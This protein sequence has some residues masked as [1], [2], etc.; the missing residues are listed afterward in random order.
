MTSSNASGFIQLD[1]RKRAQL[2]RFLPETA[3]TDYRIDVSDDG[4]I[5]LSP[6]HIVTDH[7]LGL[8]EQRLDLVPPLACIMSADFSEISQ[9][10]R[11]EPGQTP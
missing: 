7:E 5:T 11:K 6:A 9:T 4:V 8:M 1:S 2:S 3:P 10:N